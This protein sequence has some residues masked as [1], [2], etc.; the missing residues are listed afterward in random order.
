MYNVNDE[1]INRNKFVRN[2]VLQIIFIAFPL[3]GFV[4]FTRYLISE[5]EKRLFFLI[6]ILP[7]SIALCTFFVFITG[8]MLKRWNRTI[9]E[10]DIQNNYIIVKTFSVLWLRS[11]YYSL[12]I[13]ECSVRKSI[14]EWYGK[15]KK[16]GITIISAKKSKLFLVKEY[17]DDY[18]KFY[19]CLQIH[20]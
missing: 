10:I 20:L 2:N 11:K 13:S 9:K 1:G 15:E 16:E 3:I 18:Q 4:I 14:F 8:L 6:V 12:S 7:F 19:D 5:G 17:F